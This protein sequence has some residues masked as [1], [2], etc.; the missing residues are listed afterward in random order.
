MWDVCFFHACDL[1]VK[2]AISCKKNNNKT[3]SPY[4][5]F[6]T[7]VCIQI[8]FYSKTAIFWAIT[9]ENTINKWWNDTD[10]KFSTVGNGKKQNYAI[11]LEK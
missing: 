3:Y 5:D 1:F 2:E 6:I 4:M 9:F 7:S 11:I 10:L 8:M